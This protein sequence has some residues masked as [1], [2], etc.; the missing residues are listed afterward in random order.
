MEYIY[1]EPT[2]DNNNDS[3]SIILDKGYDEVWSSLIGYL[4]STFFAIDNLEKASGLITL[5]F[6]A[7]NPSEFV[8]GG[9]LSLIDVTNDEQRVRCDY[10]DYFS[11]PTL[12]GRMNI[13]VVKM[14]ENKTQVNIHARYIV[15]DAFGTYVFETNSCCPF[16]APA[17]ISFQPE[18][19][20]KICPTYKAEN[21]IIEA[22]K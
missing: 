17:P 20:G 13:N 16:K 3:Y 21:A 9:I 19:I 1:K 14:S 6:G 2:C 5:T 18:I 11:L 7:S 22:L 12:N 8:T 4:A 10:I 15:T